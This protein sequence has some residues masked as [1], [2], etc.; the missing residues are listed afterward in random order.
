MLNDKWKEK[1]PVRVIH[2]WG[3]AAG[4]TQSDDYFARGTKYEHQSNVRRCCSGGDPSRDASTKY[5]TDFFRAH[6]FYFIEVS[7][8]L[9]ET[10]VPTYQNV[11][12]VIIQKTFKT[13]IVE[14][15]KK[16]K[17]F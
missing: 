8:C 6:I 7:I 1:A 15:I 13:Y 10:S 3:R 4:R 5:A 16:M 9:Y 14:I 11:P 12:G 2:M 17:I